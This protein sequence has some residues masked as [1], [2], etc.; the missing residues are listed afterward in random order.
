MPAP[1]FC[2]FFLSSSSPWVSIYLRT[3]SSS[4]RTFSP[5][6]FPSIHPWARGMA[7]SCHDPTGKVIDYIATQ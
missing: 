7:A 1:P 2:C 6:V 5:R 3:Y 4:P